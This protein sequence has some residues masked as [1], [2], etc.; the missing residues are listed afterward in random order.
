MTI[1]YKMKILVL[2]HLLKFIF[3]LWLQYLTWPLVK[4]SPCCN[5]SMVPTLT[6]PCS[7]SAP[8]SL[9]AVWRL[10]GRQRCRLH[11]DPRLPAGVPAAPELPL[12]HHGAG[13]VA[14]HRPQLQPALWDW[15]VGLQVNGKKRE[16]KT[17]A[18]CCRGSETVALL[19]SFKQLWKVSLGRDGP[20]FFV[21]ES[22]KK[23]FW[24]VF[25]ELV[26]AHFLFFWLCL[27]HNN[28]SG[29]S[30]CPSSLIITV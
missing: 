21:V 28:H 10:P 30:V 26:A 6:T 20:S 9:G 18:L 17:V 25:V 15:E 12:D 4:T 19:R 29:T 8:Y 16:N 7:V 23:K 2:K 5:T 3:A 1:K 24:A 27:S 13:G 14:T 22:F 11:H